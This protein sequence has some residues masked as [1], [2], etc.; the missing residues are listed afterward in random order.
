MWALPSHWGLA[1]LGQ[2]PGCALGLIHPSPGGCGC[3]C[4]SLRGFWSVLA[5]TGPLCCSHCAGVQVPCKHT[6]RAN[7]LL[8]ARH[9]HPHGCLPAGKRARLSSWESRISPELRETEL[10]PTQPAEKWSLLQKK[11]T[12]CKHNSLQSGQA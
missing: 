5:V 10:G 7:G 1:A 3:S 6:A 8:P 11:I 9:L 2:S 12:F 4:L